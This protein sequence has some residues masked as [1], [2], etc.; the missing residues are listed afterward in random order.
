MWLGVAGG[1]SAISKQAPVT[2]I[3]ECALVRRSRTPEPTFRSEHWFLSVWNPYPSSV[4]HYHDTGRPIRLVDTSLHG[5]MGMP[6]PRDD[7]GRP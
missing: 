4:L 2:L 6:A 7:N 3:A 1:R 5:F